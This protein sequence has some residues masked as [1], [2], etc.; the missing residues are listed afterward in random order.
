MNNEGN[1]ITTSSSFN[2]K[3]DKREHV[4]TEGMSGKSNDDMQL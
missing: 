1:K 3:C 2:Y 4:E